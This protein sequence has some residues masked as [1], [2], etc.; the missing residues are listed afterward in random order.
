M[1]QNIYTQAINDLCESGC[2][3]CE[4]ATVT[5]LSQPYISAV[6]LGLK[7]NKRGIGSFAAKKLERLYKEK[8]KPA[9][10]KRSKINWDA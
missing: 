2:T 4:I 6:S 8:C 3:Q 5:G 7:G 9:I 10:K 1:Q